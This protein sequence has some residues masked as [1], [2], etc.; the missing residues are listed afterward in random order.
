[1]SE[2]ADKLLVL[3]ELHN[4]RRTVFK[5][6]EPAGTSRDLLF[7][8]ILNGTYTKPFLVEEFEH[9]SMCFSLDGCTQSEMRLDNPYELVSEYTRKMMGFLVLRPRPERVLI[10]GLGGGSLVKYC[11]RYLPSARVTTV[12]IDAD[13]IA[14][15][16]QFFIPPD[17]ERLQVVH[18]DGA[19]HVAA[20]VERGERTDAILVDAYDH[21]GIAK[22]VVEPSFIENAKQALGARGVFVMNLVAELGDCKKHVET[23]RRVFGDPVLVIAMQCGGNFV[24]FAGQAL[25]DRKRLALVARNAERIEGKLG[26]VFPTLL[27]HLT[28][29]ADKWVFGGRHVLK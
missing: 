27:R 28:E 10:V 12:E 6:C 22:A 11:H 19:E 23:I 5:F 1:M 16:S 15:R 29:F 7:N 25:R 2:T 13:V 24:V 17:D 14:L 18:A 9:R 3:A 20:M 26:L 8:R 21:T 4:N